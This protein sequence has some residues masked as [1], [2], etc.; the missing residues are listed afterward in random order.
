M[1]D[2][3][4]RESLPL[5][6]SALLARPPSGRACLFAASHLFEKANGV[7]RAVVVFREDD[8]LN[9]L[10]MASQS[11]WVSVKKALETRRLGSFSLSS[12]RSP[13]PSLTACA[14]SFAHPRQG[15]EV[16]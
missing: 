6:S 15:S 12:T 3:P 14:T 5:T 13:R 1:Q 4:L 8:S 9:A 10:R 2:T 7:W 11:L 16:T